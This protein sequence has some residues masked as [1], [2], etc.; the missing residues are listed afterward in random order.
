MLE[1]SI[2]STLFSVPVKEHI[3]QK[4]T[5]DYLSWS[6]AW[7]LTKAS[8]PNMN[9]I[10]YESPNTGLN[11]FHDGRFAYVKVGIVIGEVEHIDYLPI[12]NFRNNSI[13][14]ADV[15]SMDVNKTIQ[16]STTKALAM[17]GLG[18]NLWT[19]DE[20][21]EETQPPATPTAK[22]A[23]KEKEKLTKKHEKWNDV[24]S[25]LDE[26]KSLGAETIIANIERRY[27]LT[28]SLKGILAKKIG[29]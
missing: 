27:Q 15:T 22:E 5:Q 20:D 13:P 29:E 19:G 26:N 4:G 25:Y 8:F 17:H 11:F 3:S 10:V 21:M 24:M 2:F 28:E 16:R 14:L 7:S 12:M 23:V 6:K 18:L 1:K 9:R